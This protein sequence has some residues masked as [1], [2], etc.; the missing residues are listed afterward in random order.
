MPATLPSCS[1]AAPQAQAL[2][3]VVAQAAAGAQ[4]TVVL[5]AFTSVSGL[6]GEPCEVGK[7]VSLSRL[8]AWRY[9]SSALFKGSSCAPVLQQLRWP[10]VPA[11]PG[12][13]HLL[14]PGGLFM[15]AD[16]HAHAQ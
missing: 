2:V 16:V 13:G 3:T 8:A 12:P 9:S 6:G 7:Y 14:Q 15:K 5:D 10:W 1:L 11:G 4:A